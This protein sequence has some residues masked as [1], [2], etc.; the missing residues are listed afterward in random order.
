VP[1]LGGAGPRF[2]GRREAVT[3][4]DVD[5]LEI[6]RQG[7][8]ERRAADARANERRTPTEQVAHAAPLH[9]FEMSRSSRVDCS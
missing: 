6:V 3:F 7:T 4:K 2:G 1:I 9:K 8:R 5:L